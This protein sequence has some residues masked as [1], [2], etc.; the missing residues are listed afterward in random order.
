MS[1]ICICARFGGKKEILD[2]QIVKS[3]NLYNQMKK[4]GYKVSKID[5]YSPVKRILL[6]LFQC[7]IKAATCKNIVILLGK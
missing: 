6:I 1:K 2:G 5:T 4:D 7:I 3:K